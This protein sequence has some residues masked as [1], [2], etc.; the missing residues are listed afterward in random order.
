MYLFLIF[1]DLL[2]GKYYKDK[3]EMMEQHNKTMRIK[4][5]NAMKKPL[6]PQ[7]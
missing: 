5:E 6:L 2:S 7:K 1:K 4:K 3:A